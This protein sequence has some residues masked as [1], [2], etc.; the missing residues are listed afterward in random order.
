MTPPFLLVY[1][2]VANGLA[3]AKSVKEKKFSKISEIFFWPFEAI[4]VK[5]VLAVLALLAAVVPSLSGLFVALSLAACP[6]WLLQSA[7]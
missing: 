5:G 6:T 1:T 4:I 2:S 3:I 7:E